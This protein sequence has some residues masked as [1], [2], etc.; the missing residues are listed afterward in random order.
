[1]TQLFPPPGLAR[2]RSH[3]LLLKSLRRFLQS[4]RLNRRRTK[5]VFAAFTA[6]LESRLRPQ[7]RKGIGRYSRSEIQRRFWLV[8]G[9]G[10]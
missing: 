7:I 9:Q 4:R 1:M 2:V 6:N 5:V 3:A 10:Q 8:G